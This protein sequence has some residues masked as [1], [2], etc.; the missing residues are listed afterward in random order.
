[1]GRVLTPRD[2]RRMVYGRLLIWGSI[3]RDGPLGPS[4]NGTGGGAFGPR[5]PVPTWHLDLWRAF[6]ALNPATRG[7]ADCGDTAWLLHAPFDERQRVLWAC[8]VDPPAVAGPD[9]AR[10]E[11][12]EREH[13][14]EREVAR[15]FR[16]HDGARD[17]A[18]GRRLGL[19]PRRVRY[20]RSTAV[21]QIAA[22]VR[23]EDD[24]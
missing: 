14:R 9:L 21:W 17:A 22:F 8:Y 15:A 18:I 11:R 16:A 19:P 1:M 3:V 23:W 10:A 7:L 2:V 20:L 5:L 4:G 13:E 12:Q 6:A 24:E